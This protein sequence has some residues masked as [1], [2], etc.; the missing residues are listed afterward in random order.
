MRWFD[1]ITY[2]MDMGLR[3][4]QE[5][6]KEGKLGTL[7]SMGSLRVG[8]DLVTDTH[9]HTH[10]HTQQSNTLCVWCM[11]AVYTVCVICVV[12]ICVWSVGV[13]MVCVVCVCGV[14][15]WCVFVACVCVYGGGEGV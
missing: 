1:S 13:F 12:C 4:V 2:S 6:V 3:K 14:C 9:T 10:T 7:Q 5:I 8:H 15:G 11:C